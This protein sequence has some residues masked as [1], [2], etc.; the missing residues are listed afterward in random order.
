[1]PTFFFFENYTPNHQ[2]VEM[3]MDIYFSGFRGSIPKPVQVKIFRF[4]IHIH[5]RVHGFSYA[6]IYA[7]T[8]YLYH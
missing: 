6:H 5:L 3:A 2:T 4:N 7:G 8:G 1:M